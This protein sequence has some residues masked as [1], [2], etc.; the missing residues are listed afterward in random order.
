LGES[1]LGKAVFANTDF[2]QGEEIIEFKGKLFTYEELPVPYDDVED[3][4]VQ[5]DKNLYMGPSGKIDDFLNHSC[6][7]NSGIKIKGK[8]VILM[9][10][11][12]VKKGEEITWDYSTTMDEDDWE[13]NCMCK[14]KNCRKRIRDFRYLPK[15]IQQKY[16]EL[17][18]VPK[19]I[20]ENLKRNPEH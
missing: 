16:I 7:P 20:L 2:K 4:Y 18:I 1:N 6:N 10:I 14:C 8:R 3:H 15:D 9:A 11:K 17:G 5:I 19:Y 12:D 13:L